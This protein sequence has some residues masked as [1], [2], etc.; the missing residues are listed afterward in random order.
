M[1][2]TSFTYGSLRTRR[3]AESGSRAKHRCPS[4]SRTPALTSCRWT[5]RNA[6]PT[7]G[8]TTPRLR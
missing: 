6:T 8:Y 1:Y 7:K 4:Y 5:E 2:I 3:A